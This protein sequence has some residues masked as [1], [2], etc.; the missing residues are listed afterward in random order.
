M[1]VLESLRRCLLFKD[2]TDTGLQIF[3]AVAR[4]RAVPAGTPL[5]V[6]GMVGESLFIVRSGT[7]R[8]A[9]K[10]SGAER[11]LGTAGAGDHLG[12]LSLLAPSHRAC[13]AVAESACELLELQQADFARLGPQKPQACLKL[14]LAIA[15]DLARRMAD[16][17]EPLREA[18]ERPPRG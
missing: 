14:A 4:E 9:H 17:R 10:V 13:S 18:L 7:V 2:F 6:E 12:A 11:P 8:L 16:A 3:A 1:T 5:F 15:A